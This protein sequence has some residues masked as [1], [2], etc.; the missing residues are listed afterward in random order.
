MGM[1]GWIHSYKS[2][3]LG[4]GKDRGLEVLVAGGDIC[5]LVLKCLEKTHYGWGTWTLQDLLSRD[6]GGEF[7]GAVAADDG[8]QGGVA[9]D[10]T[11]GLLL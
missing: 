7:S 3:V 2:L 10:M 11:E 9:A 1:D 8:S 5:C 6:K 4:A